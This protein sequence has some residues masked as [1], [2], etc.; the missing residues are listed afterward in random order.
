MDGT[1]FSRKPRFDRLAPGRQFRRSILD[2][3][4]I[5][6]RQS[7]KRLG[8]ST[9]TARFE[10]Q[11][12]AER[13]QRY[14]SATAVVRPATKSVWSERVI[15]I[16]LFVFSHCCF[17]IVIVFVCL[18]ECRK[19]NKIRSGREQDH[20]LDKIQAFFGLRITWF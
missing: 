15:I 17:L 4:H 11:N 16:K 12:G 7:S 19:L 13:R 8:C 3:R 18:G 1:V 14:P 9:K 5:P 6:R 10:I 20:I 2:R